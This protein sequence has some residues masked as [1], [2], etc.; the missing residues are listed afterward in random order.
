M[1]VTALRVLLAATLVYASSA[2]LAA[3]GEPIGGI[4]VKGGSNPGGQMQI[5]ATTDASGEF[6]VTFEEGGDYWLQFDRRT[7][8]IGEPSQAELEVDYAINKHDAGSAAEPAGQAQ[9]AGR[10]AH[11]HSRLDNGRMVVAVPEG[12]AEIRGVLRSVAAASASPAARSICESGVSC[13]PPKP[14]GGVKK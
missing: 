11:L 9:Q 13:S 10:H 4:V 1:N 5:L 12:G 6:A 2:V 3:P 8:D 14:K 7:S